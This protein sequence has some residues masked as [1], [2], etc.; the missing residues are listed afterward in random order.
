MGY[1]RSKTWKLVLELRKL[2][3]N[4]R[5]FTK[6]MNTF[7]VGNKACGNCKTTSKQLNSQRTYLFLKRTFDIVFALSLFP[8]LVCPMM[9]IALL[10][11]CKDWGNPFYIQRRVGYHGRIIS[12]VKFRSMQVGADC[13]EAT[14]S[15]EQIVEY[16][17]DYKLKNDPRLIGYTGVGD[18]KRCF[19][20]VLRR[21]SLDELPQILWNILICG[22]MS[23][24]GPRPLLLE[25]LKEN[26]TH[27]EQGLLLSVKP[28]L[29]G[30]WQAYARNKAS[31]FA[32][33]RQRM[34]L[35][36]IRNRSL[37][38]DLRIMVATLKSVLRMEGAM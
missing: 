27:E 23:F 19:G 9:I 6:W 22:N 21:T 14:L 35:Y 15:S 32:G 12:V 16:K 25:E 1:V 24:V 29:T 30:Y 2:Q 11:I 13:L 4:P 17:Q 18:C 26:Y 33:E 3:E 38:F 31:Y 5:S 37:F 20:A 7:H 34:E 10:I 8:L 28:G 36:Y